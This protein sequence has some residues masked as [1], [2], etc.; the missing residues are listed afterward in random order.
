MCHFLRVLRVGLIASRRSLTLAL[1]S[2][3]SLSL[4]SASRSISLAASS[5][6]DWSG[7]ASRVISLEGSFCW[8]VDPIL[9]VEVASASWRDFPSTPTWT[10][11]TAGLVGFSNCQAK[12]TAAT[13]DTH[14]LVQEVRCRNRI[15]DSILRVG[16]LD[17]TL[18]DEPILQDCCFCT[19]ELLTW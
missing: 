4:R 17:G 8:S 18:F 3:S 11:A 14:V 10:S 15:D 9:P 2:S 13:L 5:F 1:F 19:G 6:C 7:A 12:F 16:G